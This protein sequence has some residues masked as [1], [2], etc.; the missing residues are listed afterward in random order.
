MKKVSIATGSIQTKYGDREAIRIAKEIGADAIDFT[1][2][3]FRDR[4]DYRNPKSVYALPEKEIIAYYTDLKNY[5]DELGIEICQTHG[6]GIGFLGKKED[7]D[8]LIKNARID[9]LVTKA[10][11][12]PVT[13]IHPVST[14]WHLDAPDEYLRELNYDMFVR[15][16]PFAKEFGVQV[17]AETFGDINSGLKCELFGYID[18]FIAMYNRICEVEDYADW[19]KICVDTGHTNKATKYEGNPKPPQAIRMLGSNITCLHLNDNN[20]FNDQHL[21]PFTGKKCN[22]IPGT[23]D[24]DDT[25]N[26]LDEIG[27]D[28]VYNLELDLNRYGNYMIVDTAEFAIKV[29]KNFL[30]NR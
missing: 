6:R 20:A 7:D 2:E 13:V 29:M 10:L 23:I 8:A 9:C 5:A 3:D 11:G 4:Y 16:L 14:S 1:L 25:L 15:I 18:E 17:A 26:A 27:Y 30:N 22:Q 24:W 19:F 12:A 28:G 21:I